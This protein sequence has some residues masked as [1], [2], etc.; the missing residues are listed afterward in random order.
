VSEEP[1]VILDIRSEEE[2]LQGHIPG[3]INAQI[4]EL[5]Y[6]L[7]DVEPDD[8]I[9]LVCLTGTRAHRVKELLAEEGIEN[10]EVL[11]GGMKAYKGEIVRGE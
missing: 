8:L 2:F 10:V 1:K 5:S 6:V 7:R 3:A 9:L 4:S 11:E